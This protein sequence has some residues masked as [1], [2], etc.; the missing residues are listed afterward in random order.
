MSIKGKEASLYIYL[1]VPVTPLR[2]GGG[3]ALKVRMQEGSLCTDSL[4]R[5]ICQHF[6]QS[7]QGQDT[8]TLSRKMMMMIPRANRHHQCP[9]GEPRRTVIGVASLES[10]ACSLATVTLQ[11]MYLLW[12][13]PMLC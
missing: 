2:D 5:F 6:L 9:I 3:E 4:P 8:H 12:E 13:F 11:A 1:P 7:H 10:H